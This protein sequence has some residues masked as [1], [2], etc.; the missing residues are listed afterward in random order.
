MQKVLNEI[1]NV[2]PETKKIP[3]IKYQKKSYDETRTRS[4]DLPHKITFCYN[5]FNRC[6]DPC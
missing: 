1:N 2:G 4:V 6:H 5:C 3:V